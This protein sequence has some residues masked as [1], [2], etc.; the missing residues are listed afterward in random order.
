[1]SIFTD[2]PHSV[3]ETYCEHTMFAWRFAFR[4]LKAS[5]KAFVHG[6]LPF[7][8]MTDASDEVRTLARELS[9]RTPKPARIGDE[10]HA[11]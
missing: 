3:D 9:T 10:A 8:Y 2:H 1:M 6:I 11:S 7:A 5:A 4:L